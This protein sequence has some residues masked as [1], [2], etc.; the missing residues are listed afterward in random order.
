MSKENE[1]LDW[2][3]IARKEYEVREIWEDR[4]DRLARFTFSAF[5]DIYESL[6][7]NSEAANKADF[8]LDSLLDILEGDIES[9]R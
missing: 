6:E 4:A 7:P 8:Y 2:E 1:V 9:A 3:A 5:K